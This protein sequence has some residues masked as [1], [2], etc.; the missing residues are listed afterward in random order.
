MGLDILML[1][2]TVD[3]GRE[4]DQGKGTRD[5]ASEPCKKVVC[6]VLSETMRTHVGA[7]AG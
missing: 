4:C 1:V 2:L 7:Q 6:R 3:S 5:L